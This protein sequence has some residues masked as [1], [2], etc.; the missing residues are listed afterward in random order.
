MGKQFIFTNPYGERETITRVSRWLM[1]RQNYN[2][3][4]NNSLWAYVMDGNGETPASDRFN[5][6]EGLYLDYF[7]FNGRKYALDQFYRLESMF[8]NS[9]NRTFKDGR[10]NVCICAVDA[11]NYFN[12]LYLELD[13][14]GERVR[15]YSIETGRD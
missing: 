9:Q 12:P 6:S 1:I 8:I 14:S 15:L 4:S 7:N 13:A 3:R 10:E 2:P 11:E 5:P